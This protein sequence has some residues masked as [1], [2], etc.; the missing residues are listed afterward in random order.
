MA[1]LVPAL[2]QSKLDIQKGVVKNEY[3]QNYSNRPYGMVWPL[4][5]EALYPPQHPYSWMTIGVME[6]LDSA[7]LADV[8]AFFQR[9]YVPANASLAIVGDIDTDNMQS[10]VDRYFG[11][12]A[13][14][15]RALCPW[16]P[17][18][19]EEGGR[20]L[21]LQDRVE[22]NRFYAVWHTV[23][24]FHRDDATLSLLG[25]ILARGKASRLYQKLVIDRQ[26][27]QDVIAYHSARELAGTFGITATLRP[28]RE[29]A[30]ARELI[31]EEVRSIADSGVTEEELAR[32]RT[33]KTASFLFAL[34]HMGG[35]GGV[36]DR[37]NAYNVFRGDPSLITS[38]LARFQQVGGDDVSA[39]AARYLV[40]RPRVSLEVVGRKSQAT[41][42]P[43][44]RR[45]APPSSAPV[46]YRAPVP[47][48]LVLSNGISVWVLPQRDLP[49]V[50]MTVAMAG[51]GSLQPPARAGLAQL[52]VSMM[53]EGTRTRT[54][55]QIALAAEA[56]GTSLSTSCG[57][58]GAF[59]SFRCLKAFLEPSLDL[60]VDVLREPAFEEREWRRVHGQTIAALRSERDSAE[61]RA[62]RGLLAALYDEGHPYRH[63]LDGVE[64]SVIG[65]DRAE[66]VAFHRESLG[67]GRAGIVVAGDV[68]PDAFL[69]LLERRLA[70]WRG[71]EIDL[72]A[73]PTPPP[74]RN[75]RIVLLDRPRA[76]QAVVRVG[77]IGLA[78][79]DRD[80]EAA[81]LVNQILGGQFTSRLNEKLR[82]ERGFTYGVRSHF[83]CRMG[84]GPFSITA[85]LQSDKL[86]EALE[87]LQ[88]E[89]LALV[90]GRPPRQDELDDARRALIEG[91][92]RQFDTPS[93][94]VN[95]YA[96]LLIHGLPIDHYTTFPER[97]GG[98]ELDELHAAAHRQVRPNTLVAVVV[99][100]AAQVVDP[101]KR[102]D[103]A[104]VEQ[105]GDEDF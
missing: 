58:D 99:A 9:Y 64:S 7:S 1:H 81:V 50:A 34:E 101:L 28:G 35:F 80:F 47:V 62:Y 77:H 78:R 15:T 17:A 65:L 19:P 67:P 66:A 68:D 83:D 41:H 14:G 42:P 10:C 45:Q 39:A 84:N 43:L 91:Q 75:P 33:M 2:D 73:I 24:H 20:D 6:D 72:P 55:L 44:D 104:E 63:P 46:A 88:H 57:W 105:V 95:R 40:G 100:D 79:S 71:Q 61:S 51:G 11:P 87:D 98:I 53:D 69:V 82:E 32:V 27:A 21:L 30:A 90:G 13:G 49:T 74:A 29:I 93:S 18:L 56:M 37:L 12:V 70:D 52:A 22:L 86:A 94:L 23:P 102:L 26:I 92:T 103:W 36:A 31:D 76:P 25:D 60:A 85:S 97:I 3:R 54:S 38:D 16:A 4:L 59:V 5:S 89:V 96:N 48:S 8:S